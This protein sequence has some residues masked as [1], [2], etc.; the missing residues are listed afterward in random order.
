[1]NLLYMK[2][3]IEVASAGSLNKAAERLYVDQANLSRSIKELEASLGIAVFERSARGM[4]PT[5]DGEIFLKY[6][7]N[8]LSQIDTVENMF[9]NGA[10]G[11]SR[12]SLSAPRASYIAEA[13]T[14]FTRKLPASGQAEI[15]Y[16]ETNSNRTIINVLKDDY[17]L[18]IIRYAGNYDK[19][20]KELLND[21]G[22]SGEL[23]TEFR[24]ILLI[25]ADSPLAKK[26]SITF[27][28]LA[29][30]TEIAHADPYVPSLPFAEVKKEE[31][32]DTERRIFVFE[33]GSQFELL[34]QNVVTY[35]WGS[36][37][38]EHLLGRYNL[39]QRICEESNRVY[40]DVL[41]RARDYRFSQL[42][43]DFI[44][45]LCRVKREIFK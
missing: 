36:P 31:L 22:L 4:K 42:D 8:I 34:S 41:I 19:Y 29:P 6:A 11:K 17:R 24:H 26:D 44:A 15:Y 45:E 27:A 12:F 7:K 39:V 18:G 3:A 33:R 13:C 5:P 28:D 9:K 43:N 1:M 25:S 32:P 2:Y 30:L 10:D 38:P 37:V 16:K 21:K 23:I 35:M 20:Y 14:A 40:K